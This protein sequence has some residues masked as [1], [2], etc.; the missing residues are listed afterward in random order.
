MARH[1]DR[2]KST[3]A[4]LFTF[5]RGAISWESKLCVALSTIEEKYIATTEAG[6]QLPWMKTFVS[7]LSLTK[8]TYVIFCDSQS[9]IDLNNNSMYHS[10]TK[11][12]DVRYHL[13]RSVVEDQPLQFKKILRDDNVVDML[14]KTVSKEKLELCVE[15]VGLNTN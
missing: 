10:R 5:A 9:S 11:H 3:S 7:Q 1:L 15:L 12:I 2:R 13:L 14:T 4:Y 6:K 8:T